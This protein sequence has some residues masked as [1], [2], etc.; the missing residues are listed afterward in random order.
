VHIEAQPSLPDIHP[1]SDALDRMI[2]LYILSPLTKELWASN[3][4][5]SIDT[6]EP[7]PDDDILESFRDT[8]ALGNLEPLPDTPNVWAGTLIWGKA[9][10]SAGK[11]TSLLHGKRG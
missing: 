5:M 8:L 1:H 2:L 10:A 9:P 7:L 4:A 6:L 11:L 3:H